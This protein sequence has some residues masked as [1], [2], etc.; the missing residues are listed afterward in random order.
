MKKILK[1]ITFLSLAMCLMLNTN[2]VHAGTCYREKMA[3]GTTYLKYKIELRIYIPFIKLPFLDESYL[4]R[5]NLRKEI[6]G[7]LSSR[8]YSSKMLELPNFEIS[9][10][11]AKDWYNIAKANGGCG[12][13]LFFYFSKDGRFCVYDR[14]EPQ[15]K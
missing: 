13:V 9:E 1:A 2:V 12:V 7:V 4:E 6:L 3:T 11:T 5:F 10:S 14:V 8:S 15:H